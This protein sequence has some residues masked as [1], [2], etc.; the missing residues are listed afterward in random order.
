MVNLFLIL[1]L[2]KRAKGWTNSIGKFS[3]KKTLIRLSNDV[4]IKSK[5]NT[6]DED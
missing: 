6:K 1:L 2:S 4:L 5:T 3:D